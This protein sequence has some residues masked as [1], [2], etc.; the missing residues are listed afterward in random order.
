MNGFVVRGRVFCSVLLVLLAGGFAVAQYDA[1]HFSVLN[2]RYQNP[3]ARARGMGGAFVGLA[4]DATAA[5]VNPA[6][7]AFLEGMEFSIEYSNERNRWLAGR[8]TNDYGTRSD[9]QPT[10]SAESNDVS[11]ASLLNSF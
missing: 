2:F 4:D 10:V 9:Y 8:R 1:E 5:Y 6:G 11:F 3:G 7:I